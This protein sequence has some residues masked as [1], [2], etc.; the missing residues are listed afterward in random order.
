MPAPFAPAQLVDPAH[1]AA[2]A[3]A[4]RLRDEAGVIEGS[5]AHHAELLWQYHAAGEKR[6]QE[7]GFVR[8]V[9][10]KSGAPCPGVDAVGAGMEPRARLEIGR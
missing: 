9:L 2:A 4:T 5:C 1:A 6:W 8:Q 10:H 7:M 3:H